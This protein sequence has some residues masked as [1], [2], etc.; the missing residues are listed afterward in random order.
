M[1]IDRLDLIAFGPF[2]GRALDLSAGA[3]G[4]HLIH[5]PNEAGKSS[6]LRAL[7]QMLFGIKHQ[8]TD[9]FRHPY[10]DLRIGA[11]LRHEDGSSLAI[12][13]RKATKKSLF[14]GPDDEQEADEPLLADK[15]LGGIAADQFERMFTLDHA[16][17]SAGG[18]AILSAEGEFAEVLFGAGLDLPKLQRYK[19]SLEK[20]MEE[21]FKP[22]GSNQKINQVLSRL[23][24]AREAVQSASMKGADWTERT[25]RLEG[26][27][28]E[29]ERVD[30]EWS[31]LDRDRKRLE[32]IHKALPDLARREWLRAELVT[33][34]G[35]PLLPED[36]A[37]RRRG[38]EE[39]LR[40]ALGDRA[41]AGADLDRLAG[42]LEALPPRG[43][44]LD[45]AEAIDAL[46][47]EL[48]GERKAARDRF[49]LHRKRAEHLAEARSSLRELGRDDAAGPAVPL[50]SANL[51]VKIRNL[52]N[53]GTAFRLDIETARKAIASEALAIREATAE[54]EALPPRRQPDALR[55]ILRSVEAGGD[56]TGSIA[57]AAR[58]CAALRRQVGALLAKL[59]GLPDD[60]A[61]PSLLPVPPPEVIES[62]R[63]RLADLEAERDRERKQAAEVEDLLL[64][65]VGK[66]DRRGREED[67]PDEDDL[68]AAR[69][70]RDDAWRLIKGA[71]RD[72]RPGGDAEAAGLGE[73]FEEAA[74]RADL[75][76][77]RLRKEAKRVAEK[78][79]DLAERDA[80]AA[81]LGVARARVADAQTRLDAEARR[82]AELWAPCGLAPRS[83]LAMSSWAADHA[84]LVEKARALAE[85]GEQVGA[86]QEALAGS[87]AEIDR[88]LEALGET[89]AP[90]RSLASARDRA[91]GVVEAIQGEAEARRDLEQARKRA[92][93]RLADAES[94]LDEARRS[95]ATWSESWGKAMEPL[96]LGADATDA[97]ASATLDATAK[98][99]KARDDAEAIAAEIRDGEAEADRFRGR[100]AAIAGRLAPGLAGGD[101]EAI[102]AELNRLLELARVA[103]TRR[104]GVEEQ[105]RERAASLREA[106]ARIAGSRLALEGLCRDAG[107][108]APE[109]LPEIER[110]SGLRRARQEELL[111]VEGR[112]LPL[113]SGAGLDAFATEA[114]GLHADELPG[115]LRA[116]EEKFL[117]TDA[118][119]QALI[120]RWGGE[121][122][123]LRGLEATARQAKAEAAAADRE[124]L[125]GALESA[126]DRYVHLRLAWAVLRDAI[127]EFRK[128]NQAPVLK[129]AGDLFAALTLGSFRDLRVDLDD[130]DRPVLVG[131]RPD[132]EAGVGVE[133]MSVGTV[134]QLYLA[135]KLA[136]LDHYLRTHPALPLVV[137]DL[138]IQFDDDRAAAALEV[139]AELSGRT[140]V[141]FFTHHDHLVDLARSRLPSD[142]LFVHRLDG[143][144]DAPGARSA[145][146][147][148]AA[149]GFVS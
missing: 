134:D 61:D 117:E 25:S 130:K 100:V 137:D 73:M 26:L 17:L 43:E 50:P 60:V 62:F 111:S 110:R 37:R 48:G 49:K 27:R 84:K 87:V 16:S 46:K 23:E 116:L 94:R 135:L 108:E 147:V 144:P 139:L 66:I 19:K 79:G 40:A 85:K 11:T 4:L 36:F 106:E 52:A 98:F 112:L 68:R 128:K 127:E 92:N 22:K 86:W 12:V 89:A 133:G 138:L 149:G 123:E 8:T 7:R 129:R 29:K 47:A 41:S 97:Q 115:L 121:E 131:I 119:R 15:F 78:A 113:A 81:K 5:G 57:S 90:A 126:V 96:G 75:V 74:R 101:P 109:A 53:E 105:Q 71:W 82:W 145:V 103:N 132:G 142:V 91:E 141:L 42:D 136:L 18:E 77:D 13:R 34:E 33:L 58:E 99:A 31:R 45:H 107:C 104:D 114:S 118:A 10:K 148:A 35:T 72:R 70:R 20:Q 122:A 59:D 146:A 120:R 64:D 93:A 69:L 44:I 30:G 1:R 80:L 140:Q 65:L 102:V 2:T 124:H 67:L 125:T 54:I 63:L 51:K 38:V 9:D 76:A 56:L 32:R 3:R 95:L 21:L 24:A 88:E 6:A 83:P 14:L 39:A 28:S 55:R 143:G